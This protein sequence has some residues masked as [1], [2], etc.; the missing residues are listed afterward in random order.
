[1]LNIAIAQTFESA[2]PQA[3]PEVLRLAAAS[4]RFAALVALDSVSFEIASREVFGLIGPNG[5]GKTTAVNI[6]TGFLTPTSGEVHHLGENITRLGP[7]KFAKRGIMRTFQS[8]R[9]FAWS[10][11]VDNIAA[12]AMGVRRLSRAAAREH[13]LSILEWI[14]CGAYATSVA[15]ALPH[16]IQQRVSVAR[17]LAGFPSFVLLDEPAAGLGRQDCREL[18]SLIAEIPSRFKCGVLLIEHNMSVVMNSCARVHVL[19]S[20]RTL[21]DGTPK[22]V[23]KDKA[24]RAAYLGEQGIY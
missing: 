23:M 2:L 4:V 12:S 9:L 14:G 3:E 16:G 22:E 24:V 8:G 19:S 5:A 21:A 1:M 17:A 13:A 7:E 20:G 10:T 18:I 6:L 15:G 11:V